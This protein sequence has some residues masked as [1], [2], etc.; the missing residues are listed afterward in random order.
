MIFCIFFINIVMVND[1]EN[2]QWTSTDN[3]F[4]DKTFD[5]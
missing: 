1:K 2:D 5:I 3:L 4:G